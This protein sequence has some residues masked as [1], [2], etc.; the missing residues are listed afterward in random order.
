MICI[1]CIKCVLYGG[2]NH[3]SLTHVIIYQNILGTEKTNRYREAIYS[4]EGD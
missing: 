2:M 3:T 4:L 1:A